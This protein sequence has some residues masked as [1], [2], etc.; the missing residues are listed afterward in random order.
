VVGSAKQGEVFPVDAYFDRDNLRWYRIT[1]PTGVSVWIA[2]SVVNL[3]PADAELVEAASIPATPMPA[4]TAVA[5]GGSPPQIT[6]VSHGGHCFDHTVY[7]D[8]NDPDGDGARIEWVD[9]NTGV[10][11]NA[12]RISGK[13]G[14]FQE[15]GWFCEGGFTFCVINVRAVDR[16]NNMSKLYYYKFGCGT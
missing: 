5:G 8:W 6:S 2:S 15:G 16:A 10:V 11:Y 13:G 7:I 9:A 3:I 4:P 1:R 14:T 12:R